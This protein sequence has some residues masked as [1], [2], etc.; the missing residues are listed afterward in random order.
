VIVVVIGLVTVT[1]AVAVIA[2]VLGNDTRR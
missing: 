1:D 2:L